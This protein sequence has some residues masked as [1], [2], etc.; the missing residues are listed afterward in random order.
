MSTDRFKNATHVQDLIPGAYER[1]TLT[2]R[3]PGSMGGPAFGADTPN[4]PSS[5]AAATIAERQKEGGGGVS[6]RRRKV[7]VQPQAGRGLTGA[8]RDDSR[9]TRGYLWFQTL[10]ARR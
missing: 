1:N 10:L 7:D 3:Q 6:Q 5:L 8:K 9:L 2:H 4:G